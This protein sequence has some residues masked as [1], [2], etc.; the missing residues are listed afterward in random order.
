MAAEEGDVRQSQM[1]VWGNV[2]YAF[3]PG[4]EVW[5]NLFHSWI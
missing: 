4:N 5:E 2:I 3:F 1:F